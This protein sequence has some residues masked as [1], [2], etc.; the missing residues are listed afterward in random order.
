MQEDSI[1]DAIRDSLKKVIDGQQKVELAVNSLT[2]QMRPCV[3][4]LS[5]LERTVNGN[6]DPG[7]KVSVALLEL[8]Q[9]EFKAVSD[10]LLQR[11][12]KLIATVVTTLLAIV[13]SAVTWL[14]KGQ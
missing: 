5:D 7:L 8:R 13:G 3:K 12:W 11:M 4:R 2:E 9:K 14:V 6:G 10:K 1:L